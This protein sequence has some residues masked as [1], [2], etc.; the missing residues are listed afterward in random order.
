MLLPFQVELFFL[1]FRLLNTSVSAG[2]SADCMQ[3]QARIAALTDELNSA[4][5]SKNN[6]HHRVWQE[7]VRIQN[8]EGVRAAQDAAP[9]SAVMR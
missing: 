7:R 9:L 5:Q 3:L 6:P 1:V 8:Q 4:K 2:M